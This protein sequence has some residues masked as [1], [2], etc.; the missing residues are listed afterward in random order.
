MNFDSSI[1]IKQVIRYDWMNYTVSLLKSGL[2]KEEIRKELK[3]YLSERKGSGKTGDR[4]EY[5]MSLAVMLLM[6]I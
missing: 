1:G 5:T 4:A 2:G 3:H 6:N